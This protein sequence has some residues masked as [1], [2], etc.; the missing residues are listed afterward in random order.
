M[1][2]NNTLPIAAGVVI[3]IV[4]LVAAFYLFGQPSTSTTTPPV[5]TAP[6]TTV[7]Q[8]TANATQPVKNLTTTIVSNPST[9]TAPNIAN[10]NGYNYTESQASFSSS[11]SCGWVRGL[12]NIT[13]AAGSY[14]DVT[15]TLVQQNVTIAPYNFTYTVAPCTTQVNVVSI[16]TGNYKI[17]LATGGASTCTP[18]GPVGI[19]ISKA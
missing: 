13:V 16:P 14:S 17:T 7:A 18:S 1:T 12:M 9:A 15:V 2:K 11:G 10:C 3:V 5:T 8:T 19:R 6:A 4:I